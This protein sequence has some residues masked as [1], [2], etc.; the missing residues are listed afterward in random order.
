MPSLI[1]HNGGL[2]D[3]LNI[4]PSVYLWKRQE[5]IQRITLLGECLSENWE[6]LW[7]F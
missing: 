6:S 1:Y 3:F 2:G 7:Y 4:L 5:K